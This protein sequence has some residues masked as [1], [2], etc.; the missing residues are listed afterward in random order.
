METRA[1]MTLC[2]KLALGRE[3]PLPSCVTPPE[4]N[5]DIGIEGPSL[6]EIL[7]FL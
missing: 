4:A 3:Q 2:V 5:T 6:G 7:I 1:E